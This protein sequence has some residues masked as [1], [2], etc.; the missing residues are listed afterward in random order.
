[1]PPTPDVDLAILGGGCAGL[2]L[3]ARLAGRGLRLRIVEPRT[4]YED[5]RSWS[6]WAE[7]PG[8]FESCVKGRWRSWTVSAGG[9]S[10]TRRSDRLQYRTV[11]AGAF[12]ARALETCTGAR[13]TELALGMRVTAEPVRQDGLWRI[14]TDA[15]AFTARSVVDSRPLRGP[16]GFGQYFVGR[17]LRTDRP[18]FDAQTVDLMAFGLPRPDRIDFTYVLPFAPDHA[19]VEATVFGPAPPDRDELDTWLAREVAART[20]GAR[21]ETLREEAGFIPMVPA[22]QAQTSLGPN[23]AYAGIAGGAARPSTGYAFQRI[24]TQTAR[25]ADRLLRSE[26]ELAPPYD[27]PVTRFMDRLFLRV[28]QRAPQNGPALFLALF[29]GAPADR[30]ERFLSDSTAP[31]DRASVIAAMPPRPFLREVIGR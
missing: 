10:V 25:L 9:Q 11:A 18:V 27:A 16:G 13:D 30:L 7:G 14:E 3:A 15:G 22:R 1:M 26:A 6:F 17:E 24:A 5:D 20:G 4:A 29:Q 2:S 21:V 8:P 12:Y 19:L 31:L 28:L 23:H